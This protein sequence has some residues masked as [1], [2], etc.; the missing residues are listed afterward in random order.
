MRHQTKTYMIEFLRT[1]KVTKVLEVGSRDVNGNLSEIF[2]KH[3]YTPTDMHEGDNVK[4][5]INGHDLS[6]KW[7]EEFDLAIC[8]D[9]LEHDDAFWLTVAE[10]KKVLKKGG[11]L[12]LGFPGPNCPE[13]D[14][15]HD[16]WRFMPQSG[17]VLMKGMKD[18][19]VDVENKD[20]VFVRGR[21]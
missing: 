7:K 10:M 15:P 12:I 18:V 3:D 20:N 17:E 19:K 16:Y 2:E 14:H 21:K 11:W 4:V 6:K 5:V 9:T 8:F 1:H 13:H